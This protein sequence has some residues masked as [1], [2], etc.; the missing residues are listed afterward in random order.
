MHWTARF[1][2]ISFRCLQERL[3]E[4]SR[5]GTGDG[6]EEQHRCRSGPEIPVCLASAAIVFVQEGTPLEIFG[7]M[8]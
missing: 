6:G 3:P 8:L 7:A 1:R 4:R 2:A 5:R